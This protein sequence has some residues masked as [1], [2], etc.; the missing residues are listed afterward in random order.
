MQNASNNSCPAP[1]GAFLLSA[2]EKAATTVMA[3]FQFT[4]DSARP[5]H[6]GFS[7]SISKKSA[8]KTLD[9]TFRARFIVFS[10][11]DYSSIAAFLERIG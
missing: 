6:F 10:Q 2:Y 7:F 5:H 9:R 8:P 11:T 3:I 1:C 4:A